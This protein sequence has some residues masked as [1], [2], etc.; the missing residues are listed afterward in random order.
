MSRGAGT[1]HKAERYEGEA[2]NAAQGAKLIKNIVH[3]GPAEWR[4][5]KGGSTLS[6]DVTHPRPPSP[7]GRPA[8]NLFYLCPLSLVM[9]AGEGAG[10]CAGEEVLAEVGG[11][12]VEANLS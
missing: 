6:S 9:G 7:G 11:G 4:A 12:K 2:A 1:E 10:E 5:D 3:A 8:P